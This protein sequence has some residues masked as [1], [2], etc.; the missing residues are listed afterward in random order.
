MPIFDQGY[1]HWTGELTGHAW[2]WLA[3]TR[4]GVRVGMKNRLLATR[5]AWSPGCR[6]SALVVRRLRLGTGGAESD[7]VSRI[8]LVPI[9]HSGRNPRRPEAL[10]RRDLDASFTTTSF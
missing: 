6:P 1:Q 3:I 7:I 4:H 10:S 8:L 5:L 2:R 9:V